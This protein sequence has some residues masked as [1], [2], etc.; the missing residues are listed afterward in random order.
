M[1]IFSH[2]DDTNWESQIIHQIFQSFPM[3][4][5]HSHDGN[6]T[7]VLDYTFSIKK[8]K[9]QGKIHLYFFPRSCAGA[10]QPKLHVNICQ[11]SNYKTECS[12]NTC[13]T[14]VLLIYSVTKS[15]TSKFPYICRHN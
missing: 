5:K 11:N 10:V 12:V 8:R 14:H 6:L 9:I 13:I 3:P 1:N 2:K 7:N 4:C 15:K